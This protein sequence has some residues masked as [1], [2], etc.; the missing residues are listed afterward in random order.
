MFALWTKVFGPGYTLHHQSALS[1]CFNRVIS[2]AD[3]PG[4]AMPNVHACRVIAVAGLAI[5]EEIDH[6]R[7]VDRMC[8]RHHLKCSVAC[9]ATSSGRAM[10]RDIG[11]QTFLFSCRV[12]RVGS[13]L[14]HNRVDGFHISSINLSNAVVLWQ[15]PDQFIQ[16]RLVVARGG[17][18][19][20]DR[21]LAS[22][23]VR[24]GGSHI[25]E[26]G[27]RIHDDKLY[28]E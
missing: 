6:L 11:Y 7:P 12:D 27:N 2:H 23:R 9:F 28:A 24:V 19:R 5:S 4:L 14:V 22:S 26:N 10:C 13:Q 25:D 16:G 20:I 21:L 18:E 8:L 15:I 3:R 1:V 17:R